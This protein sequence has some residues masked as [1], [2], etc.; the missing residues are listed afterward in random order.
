MR[1]RQL[2]ALSLIAAPLPAAAQSF[3]YSTQWFVG[4]REN[5]LQQQDR[6]R[7]RAEAVEARRVAERDGGV[8]Q[9]AAKDKAL[10]A[11]ATETKTESE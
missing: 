1:F 2:V 8:A 10:T 3:A 9:A 4:V 7:A 6:I 11:Q 5:V